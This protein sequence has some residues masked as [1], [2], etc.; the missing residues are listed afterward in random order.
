MSCETLLF[1]TRYWHGQRLEADDLRWQEHTFEQLRWWHNRAMHDAVGIAYGLEVAVGAGPPRTVTVSPG[2]AYD[3]YGRELILTHDATLPLPA[4]PADGLLLVLVFTEPRREQACACGCTGHRAGTARLCWLPRISVPCAHVPLARL[5][6]ASLDPAFTRLFVRPLRRPQLATAETSRT[7]T[8]WEPWT[9]TGFDDTGRLVKKTVGVQTRVN[10]SAAGFTEV[11]FYFARHLWTQKSE[12]QPDRFSPAFPSIGNPRADG[13]TYQ[14]LMEG[15]VRRRIDIAGPVAAVDD[16]EFGRTVIAVAPAHGLLTGDP[17]TRIDPVPSVVARIESIDGDVLTLTGSLA[18]RDDPRSLLAWVPADRTAS[19]TSIKIGQM[20]IGV[21]AVAGFAPLDIVVRMAEGHDQSNA[22]T[23]E[24]MTGSS[25]VLDRA[26]DGLQKGD[27]LGKAR[28]AATARQVNG[29]IVR[30]DIANAF[31]VND[32]AVL[33]SSAPHLAK[34]SVVT[35]VSPDG[36]TITLLDTIAGL[37][38]ASVLGKIE[39][40]TAVTRVTRRPMVVKVDRPRAFRERDLVGAVNGRAAAEV[41]QIRGTEL[42][43]AERLDDLAAGA[44]IGVASPSTRHTIAEVSEDGRQIRLGAPSGFV[45]GDLLVRVEP[46]RTIS[47]RA[48]VQQVIQND[49]LTLA[50]DRSDLAAGEVVALARLPLVLTVEG[51]APDGALQVVPSDAARVGD[52]LQSP[53][54]SGLAETE[55]VVFAKR[56]IVRLRR[57]ITLQAGDTLTLIPTTQPIEATRREPRKWEV[58]DGTRF[59]VGDPI[60]HVAAWRSASPAV[61]VERVQGDRL[62]LSA[63][64]DGVLADDRV[65]FADFVQLEPPA[66]AVDRATLR[67]VSPEGVEVGDRIVLSGLNDL[68]GRGIQL[69]AIVLSHVAG[70]SRVELKVAERGFVLRPEAMTAAALYNPRFADLFA[71]FARKHGLYVVWLACPGDDPACPPEPET[72]PCCREKER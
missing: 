4:P 69:D 30:L 13:F 44:R 16:T 2:L 14:L 38:E 61:D 58:E 57:P 72:P 55:R 15:I 1:A 64:M 10:T 31:A 47:F 12:R 3:G 17:V 53:L 48:I 6:G 24:E 62:R 59:R 35:D 5:L 23:I 34:P 28:K 65:G 25:I 45:A 70:A 52:F 33:M 40:T 51:I 7:N 36:T 27:A 56:D 39:T 20:R 46:D 49:L 9:V 66:P 42:T 37:G 60:G 50:V 32:V 63:W 71:A 11:P 8:P 19:I 68:T 54:A 26:I 43:L 22:S 67:L 18:R 29:T 21:D 41:T